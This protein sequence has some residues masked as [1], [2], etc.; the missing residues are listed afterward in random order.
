MSTTSL[1]SEL[2]RASM[3]TAAAFLLMT[4]AGCDDDGPGGG[5]TFACMEDDFCLEYDGP[6]QSINAIRNA[7]GCASQGGTEVDSCPATGAAT[8]ELP[9]PPGTSVDSTQFYY[10]LDPSDYSTIEAVCTSAG[11]TFSPP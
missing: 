7:T 1:G 2:A 6:S 10:G 5:A 3:A 8:C 11:G 9:T 4:L